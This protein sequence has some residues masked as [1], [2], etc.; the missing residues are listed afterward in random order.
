MCFLAGLWA[1][2]LVPETKGK[3][4]EEL[5]RVFGDVEETDLMRR[6]VA[7]AQHAQTS[8]QDLIRSLSI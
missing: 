8:G 1:V 7:N 2:F 5:E 4:L 6:A 3:T